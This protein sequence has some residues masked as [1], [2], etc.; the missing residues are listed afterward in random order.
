MMP[1]AGVAMTRMEFIISEYIGVHPTA[2]VHRERVPDKERERIYQHARGCDSPHEYIVAN[3]AGP[4]I[5]L[6]SDRVSEFRL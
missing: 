4:G 5:K 3:L 6:L 2:L 1:N